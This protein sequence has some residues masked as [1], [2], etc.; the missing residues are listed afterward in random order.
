MLV[1]LFTTGCTGV[2]GQVVEARAV[3]DT[4][5]ALIGDQLGLSLIVEKPDGVT[6]GFPDIGEELSEN[7]VLVNRSAIDTSVLSN[8]M[9]RLEQKLTIA[10]FDTGLVHIPPLTFHFQRGPTSDTI[11]TLPSMINIL[12]LQLDEDIRDIKS[13]YR[14]PVTLVELVPYLL[15]LFGIILL[16]WLVRRYYAKRYGHLQVSHANANLDPPEITAMRELEKLRKETPWQQKH[17]KACYIRL[18][19]VLRN[20]VEQQFH[21]PALEQT[22]DEIIFSLGNLKGEKEVLD[23]LEQ[24]LSLSDLV[25]FAKVIPG[26]H[27]NTVQIDLAMEFVKKSSPPIQEADRDKPDQYLLKPGSGHRDPEHEPETLKTAMK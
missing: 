13:N 27:E 6:I 10:V 9:E 15:A 14:A 11:E 19:E 22:T 23:K 18:S 3:P 17:I 8:G 1:M 25:K 12:P 21:V 4:T 16:F 2:K 20:Y 7:I 26:H 24:I 5:Q